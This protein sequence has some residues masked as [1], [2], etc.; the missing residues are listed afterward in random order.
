MNRD[1]PAG[2]TRIVCVAERLISADPAR[3][4][5]LVADPMR[6]GEWAAFD[7]VGYMGTELPKTGQI[8]F[9][10]TRR[11]RPGPRSRRV[12]VQHWEAGSRY[13]CEVQA[14]GRKPVCFEIG[15]TPE[16]TGGE[17]VTRVRVS[18]RMELTGSFP[19][20]LRRYVARHLERLLDRIEKVLNT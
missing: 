7:V 17:I 12:E 14:D 1:E 6:A 16:A 15:V 9:L 20:I 10:R 19:W 3:V 11:W 13:R 4:W 5:A 18:Q 8:V 2:N